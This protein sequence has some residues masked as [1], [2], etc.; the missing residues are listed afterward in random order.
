MSDTPE[1]VERVAR[2][3]FA[4]RME[5]AAGYPKLQQYTWEEENQPYREFCL[6]EARAVIEAMREPTKEMDLAGVH[7]ESF[8]SLGL[9]KVRHIWKDM[10][11]AALSNTTKETE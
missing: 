3:L 1:M 9:L 10:I 11:D 6:S 2:A 8:R 7:A 4:K 5:S